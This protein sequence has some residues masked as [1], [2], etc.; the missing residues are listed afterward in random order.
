MV[1]RLSESERIEILIIRGCGDRTR[2]HEEVLN[3][4][5]GKYPNAQPITQGSVSKIIRKYEQ[6]GHL[7]DRSR[8]GRP[9]ISQD[10]EM[11]IFLELQENPHLPSR[12]VAANNE[13]S[14]TSVLRKLKLH[15]WHPYK[16][17]LV[18]E[19]NEDDP[20]RRIQFCEDMMNRCN[21][22]EEFASRILFSDESTF[23]LNGT[24]N[25][26][27]CRY[28]SD[29]NPHW[30]MEAHTQFPEKVNVWAGIVGD[31]IVGPFFI[32]G[33]LTGPKYLELLRDHLI[34]ALAV[35]Y[36]NNADPDIPN[37]TVWFQQDG[38]PPHFAQIVRT[39][40][41][42]VFPNRWIGR[43]GFIEWPARSPDLTPL[44]YFLWGYIKSKVYF[45]RPATIEQLKER[46]RDE[47]GAI[48]PETLQNVRAEFQKRLA[49]CQEV[50]GNQF[51][52]LL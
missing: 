51:E 16:V 32:D 17:K 3:Y 47:M 36:P 39:Y 49:Y 13:I 21:A 30:M 4:F 6:L 41:N 33:S 29:H 19:L 12:V 48:Q 10:V 35:L 14:Q 24:V 11:S 40:L 50:N 7:R 46:I 34:P 52:Q 31:R 45:N 15:K 25:R 20:D 26:Q 9:A 18:H 42:D 8:S 5:N 1:R 2:T 23:Y 44:D 28:W 27:N 37:E 43:R 38:A 22:D